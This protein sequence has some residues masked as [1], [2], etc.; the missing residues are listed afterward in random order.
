MSKKHIGHESGA[1][2]MNKIK[3]NLIKQSFY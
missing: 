1:K 3:S 2:K